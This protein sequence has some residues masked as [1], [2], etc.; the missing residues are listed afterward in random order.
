MFCYLGLGANDQGIKRPL[1]AKKSA[2]GH[3][4]VAGR[5][6]RETAVSMLLTPLQRHEAPSDAVHTPMP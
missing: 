1:V 2:A 4:V 6:W 5:T 3:V